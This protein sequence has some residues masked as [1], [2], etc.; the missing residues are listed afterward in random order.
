MGPL[1]GVKVLEIEAIGPV[2]WAAMML[3]DMG[4]DVLRIDRPVAAGTEPRQGTQFEFTGR[5]KRSLIADLKQPLAAQAVLHLASRADVLVEGMR[6][7]VMERLGLGPEPCLERNP[8]LVYGRMTGW[9]Q[10]GPLAKTVGHDINYIGVAGVLHTIGS[11]N[12]PPTVPLN[13]VGD[14]GGGGM[15]LALGVMAALLEARASGKGQVVDAAMVDGSLSLMAPTL[16]MWRAGAWKD[17]R[18]GNLLDGGAH[19]YGTYATADG[20]YLAVGAIEPR[21]YAALLAGL[22]LDKEKLPEQLDRQ[23]WPEMRKKF[24][25]IIA[26]H[27]RAHWCSVFDGTEACVSPVLSLEELAAH[28]HHQ[29]RGNFV[30][31]GGVMHPAPAP[32]FSRTPGE[33]AGPPAQPGVG[34]ATALADWGFDV[35]DPRL[36]GLEWQP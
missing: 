23:A 15:L 16:G 12:G 4:A 36:A 13:L 22:G 5:G 2:P 21:F 8:A 19:F 25:D 31:V 32:R 11:A 14:Y 27:T 34:A 6:P 18:Q 26:G 17:E 3:A 30:D 7:G 24:A 29:A 33:I 10:T 20:K 1:S 35:A 28:P 9:G